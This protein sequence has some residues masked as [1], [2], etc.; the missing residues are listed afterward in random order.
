MNVS[1]T[2]GSLIMLKSGQQTGLVIIKDARVMFDRDNNSFVI[3]VHTRFSSSTVIR[4]HTNLEILPHTFATSYR[5]GAGTEF[6]Q[7]C[8][9]DT[10]TVKQCRPVTGKKCIFSMVVQSDYS[11]K[12][13]WTD[14]SGSVQADI[15]CGNYGTD[16]EDDI[17]FAN[18][19]NAIWDFKTNRESD[20]EP[21]VGN[22]YN[23]LINPGLA[24][25]RL[26]LRHTLAV[27]GSQ[28]V[29]IAS[30]SEKRQWRLIAGSD[31]FGPDASPQD[32]AVL[33]SSAIGGFEY[34]KNY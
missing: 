7:L 31:Q 33:G 17:A 24:E 21:S 8:Q 13:I 34:G 14:I 32:F 26:A 27:Q 16:Q 1:L 10:D 5:H 9:Q 22:V 2:A 6:F 30:G 25:D 23:I 12:N 3:Y 29:R 28:K 20:Q 4:K 11:C 15:A 19:Y 18:K